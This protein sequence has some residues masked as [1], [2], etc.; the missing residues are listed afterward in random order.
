M[1]YRCKDC[2]QF[3]SVRKGSIMEGS[4]IKLQ[5]WAIAL[6][7]ATTGLRGVSSLKLHR[8]LCITQKSA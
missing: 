6:Y 5:H 7:M 1:K 2:R 4:K 8:E 3:F